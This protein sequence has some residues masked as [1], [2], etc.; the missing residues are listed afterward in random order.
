MFLE[1]KILLGTTATLY[2][3]SWFRIY[4]SVNDQQKIFAIEPQQKQDST[5]EGEQ[6]LG[7]WRPLTI[8]IPEPRSVPNT[9]E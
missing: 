5:G 8:V 4:K 7:K 3:H 2:N 6:C 1:T 9:L